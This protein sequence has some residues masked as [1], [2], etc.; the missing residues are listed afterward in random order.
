LLLPLRLPLQPKEQALL[1]DKA[2]LLALLGFDFLVKNQVLIVRALP[3]PLLSSPVSQW[4]PLWWE[5]W[6]PSMSASA[7]LAALLELGLREGWLIGA[8]LVPLFASTLPDAWQKVAV[9]WRSIMQQRG[10][11]D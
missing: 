11:H 2:E 7:M 9:D 1:L 5:T 3:S 8:Q 6:Q 4:L 10:T